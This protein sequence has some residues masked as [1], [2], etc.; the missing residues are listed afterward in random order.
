MKSRERC[1]QRSANNFDFD[2][3]LYCGTDISFSYFECNIHYVH[4][5]FQQIMTVKT[6]L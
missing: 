4:I 2:G 6:I 5:I 1:P 3:I